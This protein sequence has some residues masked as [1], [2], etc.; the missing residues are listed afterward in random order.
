MNFVEV[1]HVPI[2]ADEIVN[3]LVQ[4]FSRLSEDSPSCWLV[5]CTFGG[6]GH[7]AL[8]LKAFETSPA[9]RRHHIL[10]LD[11]D[12]VAVSRGRV[13]FK[14]AIQAGRLEI[15]QQNFGDAGD[16]LAQRP[17]LGLLAD[18]GFSSDQLED[19]SR[20]LSFQWDGPLDM[21]L[22]PE[23]GRSCLD[24]LRQ[25]SEFELE[26]ILRELGEERFSKRIAAG[27]I[28]SRRRGELPETTKGLVDLVVRATPKHSRHGK[29]HVATRTFQALRIAVN[30]EM[31]VLDR[32]LEEV[33]PKVI[34]GGRVA[35]ISFHSLEDRKVKNLFKGKG[36]FHPLTKKPIEAK[37]DELFVNPRARSAKL[38][39]AERLSE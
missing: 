4:P 29:I 26:K 38:R 17:V 5:D 6:G 37:E 33:V 2:L 18:L 28:E 19:R 36:L 30:Q 39:I 1:K 15:I 20:G 23:Q 9:L 16:L 32:L 10:A 31:E 35:V 34:P 25:I 14:E 8:F 13:R 22:N 21:R 27:L 12:P 3:S 11:Q 24:L 7:T